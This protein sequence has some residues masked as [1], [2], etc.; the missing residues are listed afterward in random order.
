MSPAKLTK[1]KGAQG[2]SVAPLFRPL[3]SGPSRQDGG[4]TSPTASPTCSSPD[5]PP[6]TATKGDVQ[7]ILGRLIEVQHFLAGELDKSARAIR[8][9]VQAVGAR[10]AALEDAVT[11]LSRGHNAVVHRSNGMVERI[12]QLEQQVEDL[13]NRSRRNNLR[14]RGLP[15]SVP[16]AALK[17]TVV[18]MLLTLLPEFTTE[19]LLLDRIHRALRARAAPP[20]GPRDVVFRF[21]YFTSKAAALRALRDTPLM[22][23]DIELQVFQDLAPST[24]A[25][26]RPWRPLADHLR[27]HGIRFAWGF[28]LKMLAFHNGAT[29]I[30]ASLAGAP[31]FLAQLGLPALELPKSPDLLQP[32]EPVEVEW[33][34]IL[35]WGL[36]APHHEDFWQ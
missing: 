21:H 7:Q 4:R 23:Q 8:A 30:C 25:R 10:T 27:G 14:I 19:Q 20:A 13:S 22:Y 12:L 16:S 32:L 34:V 35:P 17:D 15:E 33:E 26:R 1:T 36:L 2:A 9:E 5:G 29:I 6:E 31:G 28:P 18:G 11:T 24:L 3:S